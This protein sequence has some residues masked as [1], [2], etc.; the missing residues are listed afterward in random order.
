MRTLTKLELNAILESHK[1]WLLGEDEGVK[2]NLRYA[3]L[4]GADLRNAD[5]SGADL[6]NARLNW[7]NWHEARY[8]KVYVAGLQSSRKNAQLT[9]IP[10]LDSATTGCWQDNWD[11]TKKRIYD[12]YAKG[13]RERKEYDL[14]IEYINKQVELDSYEK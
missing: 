9:Y 8:V 14:A 6:R 12:V 11:N 5:L 13:T 3:D 1:K 7:V 10:S 2:A 4:S